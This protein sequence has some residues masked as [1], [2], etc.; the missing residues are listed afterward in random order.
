[1]VLV[2]C[3][4]QAVRD[5][6]FGNAFQ[7]IDFFAVLVLAFAP[8]SA[9]FAAVSAWRTPEQFRRLRGKAGLL[10]GLN[11]TTALAWSCYFYALTHLP[12]AVVNTVHSGMARL[13]VVALSA[14]GARLAQGTTIGR[15]EYLGYA[16]IALA[17]A[18]LCWVTLAS[19]A[20][21]AG[22]GS[23]ILAGLAAVMV[24]GTSITVSLLLCKRLH[25]DGIN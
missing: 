16:G 3:L 25:D 21:L 12:P 8:S 7:G 14:F 18:G 20:G 15:G 5:V 17:M 2:F 10:I 23:T 24:S 1:L 4:S 13:T 22:S 6:Y 19:D 9:M 11:L